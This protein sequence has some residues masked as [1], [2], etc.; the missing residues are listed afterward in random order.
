MR[1]LYILGLIILAI[2]I[3]GFAWADDITLTTYYPAP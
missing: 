2:V 1:K 3:I